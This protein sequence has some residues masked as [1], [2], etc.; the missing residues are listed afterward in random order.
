M[1]AN[2]AVSYVSYNMTECKEHC[3]TVAMLLSKVEMRYVLARM[4]QK[5]LMAEVNTISPKEQRI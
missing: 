4:I 5:T 3:V 2:E 1:E